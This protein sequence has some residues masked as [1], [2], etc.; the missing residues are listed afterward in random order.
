VPSSTA[1]GTPSDSTADAADASTGEDTLTTI[2][3]FGF[4]IFFPTKLRA[5]G[6]AQETREPRKAVDSMFLSQF[7]SNFI[8]FYSIFEPNFQHQPVV[9]TTIFSHHAVAGP[10]MPSRG[11][12]W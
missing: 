8:N 4:W 6:A 5:F 3:W 12:I 9:V 11:R 2:R 1:G 7:N 10:K